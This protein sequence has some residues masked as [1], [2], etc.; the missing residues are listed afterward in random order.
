MA[1]IS[2]KNYPGG[3]ALQRLHEIQ[4]EYSNGE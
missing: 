3:I 2:S 4:K 1:L